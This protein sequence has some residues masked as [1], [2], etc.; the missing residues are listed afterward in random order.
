MRD[1]VLH[2]EESDIS[3]LPA[4]K[5]QQL[6]HLYDTNNDGLISY[7]EFV[8]LVGGTFSINE[9]LPISE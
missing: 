8:S 9:E 7:K 2:I 4:S 1:L 3:R 6:M 5:L